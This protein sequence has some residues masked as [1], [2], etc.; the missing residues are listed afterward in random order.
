MFGLGV[1]A[2]ALFTLA[3]PIA[4]RAGKGVFVAV[5]VLEGLGEVG[6]FLLLDK[7][8]YYIEHISIGL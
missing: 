3:S 4:A 5:R 6:I 8:T 7:E 1:L 2:T